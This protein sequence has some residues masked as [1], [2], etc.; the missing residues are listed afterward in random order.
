[1]FI[2]NFLLDS[3]NWLPRLKAVEKCLNSWCSRSLSFGGKALVS[4]AL[5]FSRVWYVA[6]LVHM[7]PWILSELNKLVFNF[8]WSGK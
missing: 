5:A 1:M 8:F 3:D 6:S 2:G 4:N 7:P